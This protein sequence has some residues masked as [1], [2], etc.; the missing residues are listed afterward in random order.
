[1][2]LLFICLCLA[3]VGCQS[4][5][6]PVALPVAPK[7]LPPPRPPVVAPLP[8]PPSPVGLEQKVRQQAQ[9]IEALLSQN[10]ALTATLA[11]SKGALP[12]AFTGSAAVST[13]MPESKPA[14]VAVIATVVPPLEPTLTPNADGAIDLAAAVVTAKPGEPVNPFTVRTVP[15][16]AT[17]AVCGRQR[18]ARAGRR[19]R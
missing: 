19:S 11:A 1:M 7:A 4:A 2:K 14:P 15:P 6:P 3:L 5:T 13:P 16:E 17:R 10:E 12:P 8:P 9:Y 18:P